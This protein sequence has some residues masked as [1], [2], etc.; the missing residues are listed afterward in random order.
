MNLDATH[1]Y[2]ALLT[3]DA[4][5]DGAFFVGVSST[6]IYCRTVCTAKTP[7]PENCTFYPS[8][9]AAE[10]AGYRPCLRCRPELAPGLAQIDAVD[11]LA[12]EAATQIEHGALTDGSVA[13]LAAE[14]GVSE[15]H[16][17]RVIAQEFGV[18]PVQ[19]AQTQRLL[20]A[21]RLLTDTDLSIGEVA[22]A[23]GF[24][25][26]RRFNAL[27]QERYRLNP[28]GLRQKRAG[29]SKPD[30][31]VCEIA[32]QPPLDWDSLLSFLVH[33]ASVGVEALDGNR[34]LR[35]LQVGERRGWLAAAPSPDRP[36]LRVEVSASLA[37]VLRPTLARVRQVFDLAANPVKIAAH[38][39]P[40]AEGRPGLRVPGA[41][42]GFEMAV[43]AILGQQVSV[44]AASTLAA[45]FVAA[46]GEPILTP[47][48]SLTH[49]TPTANCVATLEPSALTALGILPTRA[50]SI[51]ALAQAVCAGQI[52]LEA[53]NDAAETM[54][55]LQAL[56]GIGEWTAQ[57]VALRALSWPDAFPHT[58]L[59]IMTAL[60]EK[61]SKRI[62][63]TAEQWRPWRAYAA[64]HL[65]K[66]LETKG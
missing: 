33:R 10:A 22:F 55:K 44:K 3:H 66:T 46:F 49:F 35:T 5:F 57:Y 30:T 42:D 21:K 59:G 32:Y 39:W 11:I 63:E 9:A 52:R 36:T 2:Q 61:N 14:M 54:T 23:S 26:L 48:E 37:A 28:T 40:L 7:K 4:R 16:M 51:L 6:R 17:R 38:L 8:A 45:R 34:Y 13:D 64:M 31:L 19:I 65:W 53:G 50:N 43:R 56:P 58:D 29:G 24:S 27:F 20:L 18:S 41:F 15:R 62:L 47:F 60:G 25:S 1:C 12:R